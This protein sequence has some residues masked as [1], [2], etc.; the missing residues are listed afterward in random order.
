MHFSLNTL[1]A[2]STTSEQ[3]GR[4]MA[5]ALTGLRA[6]Q[7]LAVPARA[8]WA[9]RALQRRAT[10]RPASQCTLVSPDSGSSRGDASPT[11][12]AWY[13]RHRR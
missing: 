4:S 10:G 8:P 7:P 1:S 5:V 3:E 9:A 13:H 11:A 12:C 6:V 2:R